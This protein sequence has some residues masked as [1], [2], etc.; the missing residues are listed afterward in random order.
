MIRIIKAYGILRSLLIYYLIPRY[1]LPRRKRRMRQ[2]YSSF[3]NPGDLAFD[4]GSHLGS[5]IA[6]FRGLGARCVALEPQPACIRILKRL[7]GKDPGVSIVEKA[8]G[9]DT[10]RTAL[11]I[12]HASPTLST[13]NMEWRTRVSAVSIFKGVSWEGKTAV[14]VTTLDELIDRW[15]IPQFCKIDVEGSEGDVLKGLS[16]PLPAL[17]FEVLPASIETAFECLELL[18]ALGH[19]RYNIAFVET[20]KFHFTDWVDTNSMRDYIRGFPRDGISGDIYA[21][22]QKE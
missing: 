7:Y 11:Y 18:E 1:A 6:A 14:N 4:I 12:S 22:R 10:G 16:R 19:Y 17:S 15:G 9:A 2:L 20:M 21:R 5:R 3:L 8:A 13:L